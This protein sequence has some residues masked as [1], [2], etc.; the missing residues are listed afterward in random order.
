MKESYLYTCFG[1][2]WKSFDIKL[3]ELKTL[4]DKSINKFDVQIMETNSKEW[5][6]IKSNDYDTKFLNVIPNDLRLKIKGIGSFRVTNGEYIYWEKDTPSV[7]SQDIRTFILGSP[8]GALLIQ[9]GFLVFH[10]NALVKDNQAI[11]FL[12]QSGSGKSTIAYGLMQKGWK[13]IA[14]DLVA[15]DNRGY[16]LPGI[17]R[18]KLWEDAINAFNIDINQLQKCRKNLN[19]YLV[20]GSE[21][22]EEINPKK[23]KSI[24]VLTQK[25][26]IEILSKNLVTPVTN[27]KDKF[28]YLR[29]NI[30]RPRFVRALGK[31]GLN[32]LAISK[33]LSNL[34]VQLVPNILGISKMQ[35]FLESINLL[36]Y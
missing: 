12:G 24:F 7:Y 23:L 13:L 9:K 31:E 18:I 15:L 33:L 28:I 3:P 21:I 1:L 27:E 22:K 16:V 14:D 32:F 11:I 10:G 6:L 35:N 36:S 25:Q 17:K 29:N 19:K 20:A 34:P 5:P 30:Y 8:F 26:E 2:T 4:K